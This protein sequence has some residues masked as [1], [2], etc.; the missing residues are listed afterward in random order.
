LQFARKGKNI[1]LPHFGGSKGP[2]IKKNLEELQ[3]M[4]QRDLKAIKDLDYDILDVKKT[5][6]HDDYGQNFK[7]NQKGLEI[8]YRNTALHAFKSITTVQEGVEM[9]E[10]FHQLSVRQLVKDYIETKAANF[11]YDLFI[12]EMKEVEDRYESHTKVNPPMPPSHPKYSGLAIFAL[13]LQ[14]RIEKAKEVSKII[15]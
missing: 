8:M 11:V 5:K 6:W 4:F 13:S 7:E 10:N 14:T 9:L 2:E 12:K 1:T 15:K 3:T